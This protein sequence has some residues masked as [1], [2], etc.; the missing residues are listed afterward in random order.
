MNKDESSAVRKKTDCKT[1]FW[2]KKES[3]PWKEK[4]IFYLY[5]HGYVYTN[6]IYKKNTKVKGKN[7]EQK[8]ICMLMGEVEIMDARQL[9]VLH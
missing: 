7:Y 3:M 5:A 2:E 4:V 8:Y 1:T 9:Y 6:K